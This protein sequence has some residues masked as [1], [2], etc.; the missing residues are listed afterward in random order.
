MVGFF[1]LCE[2]HIGSI[3]VFTTIATNFEVVKFG[4]LSMLTDINVN[5]FAYDSCQNP[6]EDSQS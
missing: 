1:S 5:A 3:F 6:Y 2:K 4:W